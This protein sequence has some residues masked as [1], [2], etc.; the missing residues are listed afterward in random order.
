MQ[1]LLFLLCKLIGHSMYRKDEGYNPVYRREK[2]A[3]CSY[4]TKP[5]PIQTIGSFTVRSGV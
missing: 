4:E 5:Y 2:C 1:I 3:R